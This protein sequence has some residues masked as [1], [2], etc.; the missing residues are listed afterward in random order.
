M[1]NY[2]RDFIKD[3]SDEI[4]DEKYKELLNNE[5]QFL[6]LETTNKKFILTKEK[7]L[8][9]IDD[10]QKFLNEAEKDI[11]YKTIIEDEKKLDD[12]D[13]KIY[14]N[15]LNKYSSLMSKNIYGDKYIFGSVAVKTKNGFITTIRG[16]ENFNDYVLVHEIDHENHIIKVGGRKATLNAPLLDILFKNEKVKVIVHINHYFDENLKDDEYAF[17]GTIRDSFR[18]N[19]QS[20]N[21]KYHGVFYLFDKDG[22]IL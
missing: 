13:F 4:I 14:R 15:Y 5:W 19:K 20:F 3:I 9:E 10:E 16:K 17:P 12:T 1:I 8:F 18:D 11:Y 7:S 22:N 21:I 2:K 6:I